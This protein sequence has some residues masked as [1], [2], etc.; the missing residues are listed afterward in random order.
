M[1]KSRR[2]PTTPRKRTAPQ[3]RRRRFRLLF[4]AAVLLPTVLASVAGAQEVR[5]VITNEWRGKGYMTSPMF[6]V[7]GAKW[8]LIFRH[9]SNA[10]FRVDVYNEE[11][12][13]IE[14]AVSRNAPYYTYVTLKQRGNFYLKI[15]GSE[16]LWDVQ[17]KQFLTS[18]EEWDLLQAVRRRK[19]EI[20]PL[21]SYVGRAGRKTISVT[22]PQGSWKL[23]YS[24][25][26][27]DGALNVTV[28]PQ[29]AAAPLEPLTFTRTARG[30]SATWFHH[31]GKFELTVEAED[32]PWK[33]DL[34][35][36]PEEESSTGP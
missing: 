14:T 17:V 10:T 30:T 23:A 32:T 7:N 8:R 13:R 33:I 27:D 28:T 19:K 34:F 20:E 36:Y 29:S 22:I 18:L 24:A 35:F 1:R 5:W 15:H 6:Q 25:E 12:E 2:T 4:F 9:R 21:A 3:A 11:H 31:P 16:A 26:H